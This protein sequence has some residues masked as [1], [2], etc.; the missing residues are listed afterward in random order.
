MS[1][2]TMRSMTGYGTASAEAATARVTI[3]IRGLNQRH[4]DV[5]LALPREYTSL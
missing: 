5:R 3:E 1:R 2:G 4:L